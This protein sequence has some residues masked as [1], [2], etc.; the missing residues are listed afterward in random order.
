MACAVLNQYR[1]KGEAVRPWDLFPSIE[2][3]AERK[4]TAEELRDLAIQWT[5][6]LGGTIVKG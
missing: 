6:A 4:Q 2:R 1:R 3:P 5:I